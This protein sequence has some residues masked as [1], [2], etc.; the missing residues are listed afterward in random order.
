MRPRTSRPN[1]S[2]AVVDDDKR[3][4]EDE[5][6]SASDFAPEKLSAGPRK[7]VQNDIEDLPEVGKVGA[8]EAPK[9]STLSRPLASRAGNR[10]K[11][12]PKIQSAQSSSSIMSAPR[13]AKMY[14][15][16][17]PSVHHRHRAIPVFYRDDTVE[18]L[19]TPPSLFSP[20]DI[21]PTNSMTSE[22]SLI[23]RVSKA[24][25]YNVGPGPVWNIME[26]RSC[27]KEAIEA[28]ENPE[29]E[30]C[31]RPRVYQAVTVTPG[32]KMLDRW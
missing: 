8:K 4:P 25:G 31:R 28:G 15:L 14:A 20:P 17:N 6:S 32:W 18:R 7:D 24:W 30:S 2:F 23:D 9:R 27:F 16:P 5:D 13:I 21:V 22:Q 26:D 12:P 19:N 10:H 29:Y 1:Y 11:R 3:S